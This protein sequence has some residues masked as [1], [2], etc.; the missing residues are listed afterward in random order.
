MLRKKAGTITK[1]ERAY[2][3]ARTARDGKED[4]EDRKNRRIG[5]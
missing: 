3:I 5:E 2:Y 4:G 1:G